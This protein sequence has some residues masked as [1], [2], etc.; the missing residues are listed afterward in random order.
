MKG[1]AAAPMQSLLDPET[2]I[3][4]DPMPHDASAKKVYFAVR[5]SAAFCRYYF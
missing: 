5:E 1:E 4:I 2:A 3:R